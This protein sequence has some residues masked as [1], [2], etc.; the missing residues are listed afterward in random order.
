MSYLR[1]IQAKKASGSIQVGVHVRKQDVLIQRT[2]KVTS[3]NLVWESSIFLEIIETLRKD[4]LAKERIHRME[5][6][7]S[8]QNDGKY[9][10]RQEKEKSWRSEN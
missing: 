1:S 6:H 2:Q 9:P 10:K 3:G 7:G 8:K 4:E 5:S